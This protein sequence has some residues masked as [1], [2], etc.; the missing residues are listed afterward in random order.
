MTLKN[1]A[2]CVTAAD[3]HFINLNVC[4][5]RLTASLDIY[6]TLANVDG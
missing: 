4:H 5:F 6:T 1:A 2:A 3:L